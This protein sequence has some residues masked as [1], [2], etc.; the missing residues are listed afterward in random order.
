MEKNKKE[1]IIGLV[2]GLIIFIPLFFLD[3]YEA[4]ENLNFK[5]DFIDPNVV[6]PIAEFFYLFVADIPTGAVDDNGFL[7]GSVSS[8]VTIAWRIIIPVYWI[9]VW[10]FRACIGYWAIKSVKVFY[11]KL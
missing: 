4:Y 5:L 7:K 10:R 6:S 8:N 2:I 9:L 11:K 1:R 3:L